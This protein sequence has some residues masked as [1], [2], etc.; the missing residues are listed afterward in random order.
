[1]QHSERA[2]NTIQYKDLDLFLEEGTAVL[3]KGPVVIILVE[4][5]V[6]IATTLRHHQQAGFASIIVFMIDKFALPRDLQDLLHRLRYKMAREG[7][8]ELAV[9]SVITATPGLRMYY[10]FNAEYLFHLFAK[11]VQ[12]VKCCRSIPR[13]AAIRC[14]PEWSIYILMVWTLTLMRCP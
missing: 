12:L 13:N 5:D 2:S 8:M 4:D 7:A 11:H 1:M 10:C 9:N 3:A 14:S 6:E